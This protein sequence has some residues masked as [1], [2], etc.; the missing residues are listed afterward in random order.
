M[1]GSGKRWPSR[2][3]SA[4]HSPIYYFP[5]LTGLWALLPSSGKDPSALRI[6]VFNERLA[7]Q[8]LTFPEPGT[9]EQFGACSPPLLLH[10]PAPCC[11]AGGLMRE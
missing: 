11:T 6:P 8:P 4:V 1:G 3:G 10:T 7:G 2:G 9:G 5:F